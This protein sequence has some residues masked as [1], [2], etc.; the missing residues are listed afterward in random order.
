MQMVHSDGQSSALLQEGLHDANH[1]NTALTT[2]VAGDYKM[3]VFATTKNDFLDTSEQS[4][5]QQQQTL[6]KLRVF[7]KLFLHLSMQA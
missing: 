3:D 6:H 2:R 7:H 4:F 5:V 1:G